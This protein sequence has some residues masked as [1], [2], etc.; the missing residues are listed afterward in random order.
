MK[1]NHSANACSIFVIISTSEQGDIMYRR[2]TELP[3]RPYGR[4]RGVDTTFRAI[5]T[6]VTI[7]F[8]VSLAFVSELPLQA[9]GAAKKRVAVLYFE[10]HSNFDSPTGCGCLPVGPL[11]FLFGSGG[12]HEKWDLKTGFR[13]LLNERLEESQL[14]EV[15]KLE[16]LFIAMAVNW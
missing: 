2:N 3:L 1:N 13:D 15:V 16:E 14:Y 11:G 5:W 4:P 12:K 8:I 6:L 7:F 9:N 10:N